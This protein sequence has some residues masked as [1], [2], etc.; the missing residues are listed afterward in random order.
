MVSIHLVAAVFTIA[1]LP[2]GACATTPRASEPD[3]G[4]VGDDARETPAV[5]SMGATPSARNAPGAPVPAGDLRADD[6]HYAFCVYHSKADF[7]VAAVVAKQSLGLEIVRD[8]DAL[9][10]ATKP[11][12]LIVSV[13]ASQLA[14]PTGEELRYLSRGLSD[15]DVDALAHAT[16]ATSF[17][18]HGP[19]KDAVSMYTRALKLTGAVAAVAEGLVWD[20]TTRLVESRELWLERMRDAALPTLDVTLHVNI[21][22]Y[23]SGRLLR[24]VTL[25]MDKLGLPDVV[26]NQVAKTASDMP[27]LVN[28]VAQAL[29]EAPRTA[30]EGVLDVAL[31]HLKSPSF[32]A[33]VDAMAGPKAERA[34]ILSLAWGAHDEG[35]AD[36]RL[37]EIVWPGSPGALQERQFASLARLFGP[38]EQVVSAATDD[39]ALA[40]ASARAKVEVKGIAARFAAGAPEGELLSVKVPFTTPQGDREWMWIEVLT[41]QGEQINGIL[42]NEPIDVPSLHAG[43]RVSAA[44]ADVFDYV[45]VLPDGTRQGGETDRILLERGD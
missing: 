40:A 45:H 26:V 8:I 15:A 23:Q 13:P 14:P 29:Y 19:G 7:D 11:S 6:V 2:L 9:R 5:A 24:M 16:T 20:D 10:A 42:R 34:A 27:W 21:H 31:D 43:A 12:L 39:A 3:S 30:H 37:V 25:G 17:L 1:A 41:W 35:D 18:F 36:N 28:I 33:V 32:R 4:T 38:E 44:A 22:V